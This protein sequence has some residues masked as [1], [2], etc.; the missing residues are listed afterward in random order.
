[1]KLSFIYSWF[2]C[3]FSIYF[4]QSI[5]QSPRKITVWKKSAVQYAAISVYFLK[6]THKRVLNVFSDYIYKES[7]KT[8]SKLL[9]VVIPEEE[10]KLGWEVKENLCLVF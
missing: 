4:A 1:M 7:E 2:I 9:T 8:H 6:K 10:I 5:A 3:L